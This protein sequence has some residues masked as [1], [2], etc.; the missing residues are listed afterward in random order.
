MYFT[1]MLQQS[2]TSPPKELD[3]SL[4]AEALVLQMKAMTPDLE[5]Q[6]RKTLAG[7]DPDLTVD[8]YQ[9]FPQQIH[10]NFNAERMISRLT[11]L[12]GVLAL[13]LA[14]V[15]L[16]GVTSYMVVQ[17][18]QEIGIRMALGAARRAVV[19]MVMR[20]AMLQAG[21]GL[22][23]GIPTALLCVRFVKS[24][25]YNVSGQDVWV[26]AGAVVA[27]AIS[28]CVAG[29]IPARRAASTDPMTALRS[30]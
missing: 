18:T 10:G 17:R 9:T 24:Q 16:Y 21:I 22:M 8:H 30:E 27:L 5:G 1:P 28:A 25:L 12:F 19:G 26:M 3:A 20:G 11:L 23:I 14:S 4:Y 6:I 2:R 15:G 13:V 7:I 29:L